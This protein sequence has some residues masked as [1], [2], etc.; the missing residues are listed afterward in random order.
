MSEIKDNTVKTSEARQRTGQETSELK[1]KAV[2]GVIWSALERFSVQGI[3]F[4]VMLVMARMLSP[5]D[6]G[7]VGMAAIFIAVSNSLT[8]SGFSQALIRKQD[9]TETDKSTVFYFNIV[10]SFILYLLIYLIA[11]YVSDFYEMPQLTAVVRVLCVLCVINSF[12]IVQR[13]EFMSALDFKS[14]TKASFVSAILS[15]I[16]GVALAMLGF[17]VWAL[18]VQQILGAFVNNLILWLLSKW[19][20][21]LVFSKES[22]R[23]LFSFGSKLMASGLIDTLYREIYPIVIGKLFSA[24]SLG[25]FN[26]AKHF[27]EFPSQNMTGIMQRV[28]YPVLCKIQDDG[29]LRNAYRKFLKM[30]AF[31]VFPLMMALSALSHPLVNVLIG[32]KWSFCA[33]LL[34]VICFSMMWYPIHAIN[35]NL[36]QVKGRSDLF[37]KLEVIK[38]I[39]GITILVVSAPWGLLAMCYGRIASSLIA[40]FINTYYTGVLLDLGFLKQMKDLLPTFLLGSLMFVVL[41]SISYL[42]SNMMY[43]ALLLGAILGLGVYFGGSVIFKFQELYDIKD[44]IKKK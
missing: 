43:V 24:D 12:G 9:R 38:K 28:T 23:G 11:P 15:G 32:E 3:Q 7:L 14:Q 27:A 40:L 5:K 37:L 29:S 4:L 21:I 10:V 44:L 35:L 34:Q 30:S 39:L 20:P 13:T 31:V 22:F 19:R 1:N 25:H 42:F 26:R 6:Y 18:V 16:V 17:G 2:K 8:D 36:L 33:D 41:L